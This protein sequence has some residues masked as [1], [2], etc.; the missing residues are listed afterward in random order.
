VLTV[1]AAGACDQGA[2]EGEHWVRLY[3]TPRDGST[4]LGTLAVKGELSPGPGPSEAELNAFATGLRLVRRPDDTPVATQASVTIVP[5][6]TGPTGAATCEGGCPP[7]RRHARARARQGGT[8]L[9][10]YLMT[11]VSQP[12]TRLTLGSRSALNFSQVAGQVRM[13]VGVPAAGATS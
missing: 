11:T 4:G 3:F 13:R 2:V 5:A 1:V 7:E 6:G 9:P 10:P 8:P 12:K